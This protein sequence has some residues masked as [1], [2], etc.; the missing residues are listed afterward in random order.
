MPIHEIEW[1][2]EAGMTPMEIIV[3]ATRNGARACDMASELGTLEAGKLA[4]VLV[5][6]GNPLADVHALARSAWCFVR[7]NPLK[8]FQAVESKN[9]NEGIRRRLLDGI[10]AADL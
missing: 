10:M 1:M 5:V 7:A 8:L 4:D 6:D 2:Q 9:P 3:A